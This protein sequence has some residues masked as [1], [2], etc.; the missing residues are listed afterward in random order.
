MN[1]TK[2]DIKFVKRSFE[3]KGFTILTDKYVNNSTKMDYVCPS[4]HKHGMSWSSWLQGVGC[5]HC[6]KTAKYT[7]E[8]ILFKF[9]KEN[10]KLV[11]K[12]YK[13]SST[14]LHYVCPV[15]HE[16]D[17][18][19]HA[20]NILGQRC[21]KCYN[22][23][24][25]IDFTL[26]KNSF[27]SVGYTLLSK[28]YIDAN[29]LLDYKCPSNHIHRITWGHWSC[30]VRCPT[31]HSISRFGAGHPNWQ[32]G[33]SYEPYC[34]IWKDKEY[35]EDIKIRD[36]YKCLNPCCDSK[37]PNNLVIHHIDYDKKNCSPDN[38]ITV[39]RACN[40]IANYNREWYVAWYQIILYNKYK[41]N[42]I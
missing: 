40:F 8:H 42:K 41:R 18:R 21:K 30:G 3:S 9:E 34:Q 33:I 24:R 25:K 15:G 14:K 19:W 27:T 17:V 28:E 36:G 1:K 2:L 4:G 5:P 29:T 32:G 26:I 35:K 20:W 13:N 22:D 37:N 16:G 11:S 39:C 31:C 38:L 12:E 7:Y 23:S 6:S 10:Y